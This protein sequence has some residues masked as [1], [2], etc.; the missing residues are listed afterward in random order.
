MYARIVF[1]RRKRPAMKID[2][3]PSPPLTLKPRD[4]CMR[5][6]MM[7]L[8]WIKV[9]SRPSSPT[10][11][12]RPLLSLSL[13]LFL[14]PLSLLPSFSFLPF[15]LPLSHCCA[16]HL[17][18]DFVNLLDSSSSLPLP[19]FPLTPIPSSLC[20]TTSPHPGAYAAFLFVLVQL[21]ALFCLGLRTISE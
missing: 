4:T 15:S 5:M 17:G 13:S 3:F 6:G 8:A 20:A 16:T 7:Q 18:I 1:I 19:F 21:L 2:L 10:R 9:G 11:A 12:A 14:P